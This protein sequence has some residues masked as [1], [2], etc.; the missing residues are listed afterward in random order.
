VAISWVS[1]G[2]G[3]SCWLSITLANM[4]SDSSISNSTVS[5]NGTVSNNSTVSN[6]GVS[7]SNWGN[8]MAYCMSHYG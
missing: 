7:N 8:S 2:I 1:L 4:M 3:F 6:N 5:N